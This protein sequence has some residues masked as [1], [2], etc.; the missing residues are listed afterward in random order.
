MPDATPVAPAAGTPAAAAPAA[1]PAAAAPPAA[2][3]PQPSATAPASVLDGDAK[4]DGTAK[5]AEGT[6][7]KGDTTAPVAYT[8]KVPDGAVVNPDVL[9][10]YTD[11]AQKLEISAEKAQEILNFSVG[12]EKAMAEK[13]A[14]DHNAQLHQWLAEAKSD[15]E[16][17]GAKWEATVA[18]AKRATA[19]LA[20]PELT[21]M[22][23][24]SGLGF[25]KET[26]AFFAKL[27]RMVAEDKMPKGS[28]SAGDTKDLPLEEVL[29]PTMKSAT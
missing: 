29:Y 15:K 12:Q 26:I 13:Y 5:P 16:I 18:D 27:G 4:P 14:A 25:R 19:Q 28:T 8:I 7:P 3:A 10:G 23:N 24:E 9:K 11:L 17:G 1:A 6:T 21:K 2:P 20:T 22:L